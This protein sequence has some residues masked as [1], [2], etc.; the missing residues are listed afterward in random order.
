MSESEFD[1]ISKYFTK[2]GQASDGLVMGIGDDAAI[3]SPSSEQQLLI[4]IDTLNLGVHFSE[5]STATDIG[6]KS[7]AVNLSDIAAMGGEP[8]WF[9]LSLSLPSVDHE[10]LKNFCLGLSQLADQ[11]QLKLVGGDTTKGPLSITIQIAGEAPADMVL[12]RE[13][14]IVGDNIYVTGTLGDAAAG[15]ILCQSPDGDLS[16]QTDLID[17]LNKPTPRIE[18]GMALRNIAT[19]CIDIS[20]GLAGDLGH[21]LKSNGVGA[22]LYKETIPYS[23]ALLTFVKNNK[24]N[25]ELDLALH[26]GDDYELCFTAP[27]DQH[28][29]IE[30]ISSDTNCKITRI[31]KIIAKNGLY[32]VADAHTTKINQI[33]FDHFTSS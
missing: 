20:D 27:Q 21:I 17:R 6:Y 18:V 26:G 11:Y 8:K 31:G 16:Y 29:L 22:E 14:A 4:S 2:I 9:T 32:I 15:L 1:I 3:I 24:H 30:N 13:G 7:L 23:A 5:R 10:W 25:T 19:A 33:G 28:T 12:K